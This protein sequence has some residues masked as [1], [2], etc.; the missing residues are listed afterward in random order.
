MPVTP[1]VKDY[2]RRNEIEKIY[3]LINEGSGGMM[4]MNVSMLK[5]VKAN[6]ITSE[7]AVEHSNNPNEMKQMLQGVFHG[8]KN[9]V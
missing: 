2:I 6:L 5:L 7:T 8:A 1:A 9:Q 4:S 3:D